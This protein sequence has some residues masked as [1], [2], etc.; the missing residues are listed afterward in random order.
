[1]LKYEHLHIKTNVAPILY[2]CIIHTS[3]LQEI[4]S[5]L[6]CLCVC[7]CVRVLTG[8]FVLAVL[9]VIFMLS[10][11]FLSVLF[12][13]HCVFVCEVSVVLSMVFVLCV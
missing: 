2:L 10:V 4:L 3:D 5:S 8:L 7:A 12:P 6:V 9:I 11:L 1:M 13:A